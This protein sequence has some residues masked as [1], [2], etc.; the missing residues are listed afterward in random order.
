MLN[1]VYTVKYDELRAVYACANVSEREALNCELGG[2]TCTVFSSSSLALCPSW[3]LVP[4][5]LVAM[6]ESYATYDLS[7]FLQ[8]QRIAQ[9]KGKGKSARLDNSTKF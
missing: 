8:D 9:G 6:R 7:I 2:R 4:L 3:R 5:S 1:I